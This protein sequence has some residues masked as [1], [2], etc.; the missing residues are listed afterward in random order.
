MLGIGLLLLAGFGLWLVQPRG[1]QP[2]SA[3]APSGP[4]RLVAAQSTVDLGRVPFDR[5]VEGRFELTNTGGSPVK[6][7]GKPRVQT[8]EGC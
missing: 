3:D 1:E 6:L 4:G 2:R 5:T 8:L 7:A